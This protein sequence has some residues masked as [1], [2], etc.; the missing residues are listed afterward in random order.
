MLMFIC[1][2]ICTKVIVCL[3]EMDMH[4]VNPLTILMM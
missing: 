1:E 4:G 3:K 2:D